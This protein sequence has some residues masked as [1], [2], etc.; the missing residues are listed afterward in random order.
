M[1]VF[2]SL[3]FRNAQ[4]QVD[5]ANSEAIYLIDKKL[6][7]LTSPVWGAVAAPAQSFLKPSV[8]I[9]LKV[10]PELPLSCE[11]LKNHPLTYCEHTFPL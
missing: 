1:P 11:E 10:P 3:L 5:Q 9:P 8:R 7:E 4:R 2:L 6:P